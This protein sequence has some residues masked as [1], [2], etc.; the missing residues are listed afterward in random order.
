M[1]TQSSSWRWI[2]LFNA[3]CTV[4][5]IAGLLLVF[6]RRKS[7]KLRQSVSLK[8]LKGVD[9]LGALLLL[10]ASTLLVF[11]MEQAGSAAYRW[12]SPIIIS[13]L[14]I[15]GLCW[16]GFFAWIG[17]LTYGKNIQ[18]KPILPLTLCSTR[19]I[20][21]AILYVRLN[22]TLRSGSN[23]TRVVL[24]TGFPYFIAIIHLP[25]RFQLVNG[26]SPIGAGVKL[27]PMLCSTAFGKFNT[28]IVSSFTN[29]CM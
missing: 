19:P 4:V 15:A 2:Y 16:V 17:W 22:A 7:E 8:K 13:T 27:L 23:K 18:L 20:G 25:Y 24:L 11:A 29:I 10:A 9:I 6:P 28:S 21:P 26:D 1:I 14:T 12:N 3:P 5:G